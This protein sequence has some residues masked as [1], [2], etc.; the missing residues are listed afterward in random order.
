MTVGNLGWNGTV[1]AGGTTT[2]GFLANGS[3]A[4]PAPIACT[5]R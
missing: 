1:A 2:F 4:T 3:A 5:A